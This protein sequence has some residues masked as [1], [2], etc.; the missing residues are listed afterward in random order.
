MTEI[1]TE[2]WGRCASITSHGITSDGEFKI[3]LIC[4]RTTP[5]LL[6]EK[7][8]DEFLEMV[9]VEEMD[10]NEKQMIDD[11]LQAEETDRQVDRACNP[12]FVGE[13]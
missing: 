11:Y 8:V 4:G 12:E 9:P 10:D 1:Q 3:C 13:R 5:T 7:L 2:C 6:S